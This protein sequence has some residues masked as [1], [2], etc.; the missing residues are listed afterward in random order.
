MVEAEQERVNNPNPCLDRKTTPR[1]KDFQS[2]VQSRE[3]ER[4][5]D[6]LGPKGY[7]TWASSRACRACLGRREK[8]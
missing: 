3:R 1:A 2:A 8:Q 4:D 7:P 6:L 5:R